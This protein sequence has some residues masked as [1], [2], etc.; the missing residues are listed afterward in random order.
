MPVF[1]FNS[2]I[3]PGQTHY[4]WTGGNGWYTQG[5][6]PQLDAYPINPGS[7]LVYKDF[8]CKLEDNGLLTYYLTVT[9]TGP[10]PVSYRM[11]VWVP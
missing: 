2:T 10:Y 7:P 3:N 4:W 8:S 11:R 6:K 5:N 9:N 1:Q